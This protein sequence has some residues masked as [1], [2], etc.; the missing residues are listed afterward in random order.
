MGASP[1]WAG[2]RRKLVMAEFVLTRLT[3][4]GQF[5]GHRSTELEL[6]ICSALREKTA[7]KVSHAQLA[8]FPS[9][10]SLRS[11][12]LTFLRDQKFCPC[13]CGRSQEWSGSE[14]LNP[15]PSFEF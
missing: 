1:L 2:M 7:P 9:I 5:P 13:R 15:Y 12:C 4:N 6:S 14:N 10:S 11:F 3:A 8:G